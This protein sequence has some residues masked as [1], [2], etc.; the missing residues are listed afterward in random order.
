MSLIF[1][2]VAIEFVRLQFALD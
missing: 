2:Y 1:R